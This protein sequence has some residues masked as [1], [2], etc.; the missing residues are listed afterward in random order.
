[1][2]MV[3][4]GEIST[5]GITLEDCNRYYKQGVMVERASQL[6]QG[7]ALYHAK[8]IVKRTGGYWRTYC[9]GLGTEPANANKLINLY[10]AHKDMTNDKG[11]I[12]E[13]LPT[14]SERFAG[15][16]GSTPQEKA[17]NYKAIKDKT[18]SERPTIK[19]IKD[20]NSKPA[21]KVSISNTSIESDWFHNYQGPTIDALSVKDKDRIQILDDII[22]KANAEALE[23]FP[24]YRADI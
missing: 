15:L 24:F 9:E 20:F 8:V 17:D 10:L 21:P 13:E 5:K 1:M 14:S 2:N 11:F 7:L 18:K 23:L 16:K 19:Q 6:V 4:I 22:R 12:A 3:T